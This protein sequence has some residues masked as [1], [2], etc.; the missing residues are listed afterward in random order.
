MRAK[1]AKGNKVKSQPKPTVDV[2]Q[3]TDNSSQQQNEQKRPVPYSERATEAGIQIA[4]SIASDLL[5][6]GIFKLFEY[7]AKPRNAGE[8]AQEQIN[9]DR[10]FRQ[11]QIRQMNAQDNDARRMQ[12]R[13]SAERNFENGENF[14][15]KLNFA[16][17]S[18]SFNEARNSWIQACVLP[19]NFA[20]LQYLK[21][22]NINLANSRFRAG[23]VQGAID[24][25]NE[26][27]REHPNDADPMNLLGTLIMDRELLQ[28]AENRN[29]EEAQ[30]VFSASLVLVP[31][32]N[33]IQA[34]L[35]YIRGRFDDAIRHF[36]SSENEN[37]IKPELLFLRGLCEARLFRHQDAIVS[38]NR[39][40]VMTNNHQL[41]RRRDRLNILN[42]LT[43]SIQS[44]ENQF[45]INVISKRV[46]DCLNN[47]YDL[48]YDNILALGYEL[49]NNGLKSGIFEGA[50]ENEKT[51]FHEEII[52]G[53]G[54]CG[55]TTLN[56]PRVSLVNEMLKNKH[57][58]EIR[59]LIAPE[60]FTMYIDYQAGDE[61][62]QIPREI[63]GL[64]DEFSIQIDELNY[65]EDE[66]RDFACRALNL[67]NQKSIDDL[68]TDLN[69]NQ[70]NH[71]NQEI[72][73]RLNNFAHNREE[74]NRQI[75]TRCTSVEVFEAYAEHYIGTDGWFSYI[76]NI[77]NPQN[78][79]CLPDLVGRLFHLRIFIW[80]EN[81]S[82]KNLNTL[83]L[84][85]SNQ[86]DD[87]I[88]MDKMRVVH[89]IYRNKNHFNRLNPICDHNYSLKRPSQRKE[90]TLYEKA[91]FL[92]HSLILSEVPDKFESIKKLAELSIPEAQAQY[93]ECFFAGYTLNCNVDIIKHMAEASS[94]AG[95][96]NGHYVLG[97]LYYHGIGFTKNRRIAL[98]LF[99]RAINEGN[100]ILAHS[101]KGLIHLKGTE[102][103]NRS[104][105]ALPLLIKAAGTNL[106]LAKVLQA[107]YYVYS[108]DHDFDHQRILQLFNQ[109]ADLE[110][111][112]RPSDREAQGLRQYYLAKLHSHD[113]NIDQIVQAVRDIA[114]CADRLRQADA[115]NH[116]KAG[117]RLAK[118][119][120]D[121]SIRRLPGHD[122]DLTDNECLR[123]ASRLLTKYRNVS[124]K[125]MFQSGVLKFNGN[126]INEQGQRTTL[127]NEAATDIVKSAHNGNLSAHLQL[128]KMRFHG[129]CHLLPDMGQTR[130]A[131]NLCNQYDQYFQDKTDLDYYTGLYL[132]FGRKD[133]NQALRKFSTADLIQ[134]HSAILKRH[135]LRQGNLQGVQN[136]PGFNQ[137]I[138]NVRPTIKPKIIAVP[139]V[140]HLVLII[141]KAAP[142]NIAFYLLDTLNEDQKPRETFL[143]NGDNPCI[144]E[145]KGRFYLV[146][147]NNNQL[148]YRV[149]IFNTREKSINWLDENIIGPHAQPAITIDLTGVLYLTFRNANQICLKEA[150]ID[151]NHFLH[152]QENIHPIADALNVLHFN[153]QTMRHNGVIYPIHYQ[154]TY[155][156][157]R[158]QINLIILN[159]VSKR[160]AS[161]HRICE[162]E[163]PCLISTIEDRLILA[164]KGT[165]PDDE[166]Y[167]KY[168]QVQFNA[169][170]K[171]SAI[172]W[173]EDIAYS[174][175]TNPDII[176]SSGGMN[177]YGV[178]EHDSKLAIMHMHTT[179]GNKLN[180]L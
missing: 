173:S 13:N 140:P 104:A 111:V 151:D 165:V 150:R 21:N 99:E 82:N 61:E 153:V 68:I 59:Q 66:L 86:N 69:R 76:P 12:H 17:A 154:C 180:L 18:E 123:E 37:I 119:F 64:L 97:R 163:F 25:L 168:G 171:I 78:K 30:R 167:L 92:T 105:E 122:N 45:R 88:D 36:I 149:G 22:I 178:Y 103:P 90:T 77:P 170:Q 44:C 48:K 63:I 51:H 55:Y 132:Y 127:E 54:D 70:N 15:N 19:M 31:D 83:E 52:L 136:E 81:K 27:I 146:Y 39:A 142:D 157:N 8:Q 155:Q 176:A 139:N 85:Y 40:Y 133:T 101:F 112:K 120:A 9:L 75:M 121:H 80:R 34:R 126:Y 46:S 156:D 38:F 164:F 152:W 91:L 107:F 65:A 28:P 20:Q 109:I 114:T 106:P 84:S 58:I 14:F 161:I 5:R 135:K 32:N 53:D 100:H 177:I 179:N 175:G 159:P 47:L 74:L 138:A 57:N 137:Q 145:F 116:A 16:S 10:E 33:P 117:I 134:N 174:V 79:T 131:L 73:Q 169:Q 56:T 162:G 144:A 124:P 6:A 94:M 43:E 143:T 49:D 108:I 23:N 1:T 50:T 42:E 125:A 148:C 102:A 72:L 35:A 160:H 26:V 71:N 11:R 4:T 158:N 129:Y 95:C 29:F 89:M 98:Q 62:T 2:T 96:V 60:I 130:D 141:K 113:R 172:H 3:Q 118:L 128:A 166:L 147:E 41:S 87:R 24:G 115:F 7:I 93:V 110:E 67:K